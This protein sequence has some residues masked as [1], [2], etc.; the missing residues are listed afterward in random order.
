[1]LMIHGSSAP[2]KLKANA[3]DL[4]AWIFGVIPI[5]LA[6]VGLSLAGYLQF[7]SQTQFVPPHM[8]FSIL[9]TLAFSIAGSLIARRHPRNPIGWLLESV[10]GFSALIL[11]SGAYYGVSQTVSLPFERLSLWLQSWVWMPPTLIPLTLLLL[12]F[13]NGELISSRWRPILAFAVL[14]LVGISAAFAFNP[15]Q[16]FQESLGLPAPNPFAL[17]G[18]E[19]MFSAVLYLSGG[20]MVI[21]LVGSVASVI[22]R[23]RRS[24]GIRRTQLKWMA[25]A[26]VYICV[27]L[28]IASVLAALYP[29]VPMVEEATIIISNLVVAGIAVA[30][31]V[32]IVRHGLFDIDLLLNR[33]L[34]YLGLT[35]LVIGIYV[36]AVGLLSLLFRSAGDLAVSLAAT[37]VVAVALQPIKTRLQTGV[38]RMLYGARDDPYGVISS[39]G[40]RLGST[41]APEA[42]LPTL[43]ETIAQA[44]KLPYV[45]IRLATEEGSRIAAASGEFHGEM[46]RLPLQYQSER[47]GDLLVSPRAPGERFSPT[48]HHLLED[49]AEQASVAVHAN[50]LTNDLLHAHRRLLRAREEE[51]RRIRRDL[52]DGLGTLLASQRLKIGS[53]LEALDQGTPVARDLLQDLEQGVSQALEDIR[54]LVYDL[55]PPAL[56]ELGLVRALKQSA[57]RVPDTTIDFDVPREIPDLPAAVDVAAFRIIQEALNNCV[58]HAHASRV[59]VGITADEYLELS[60]RDNGIGIPARMQTGVGLNSMRARAEELG[61]TFELEGAA[62][63]GT[64]VRARLPLGESNY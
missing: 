27:G 62:G 63:G 40:H 56:D 54:R 48:E 51:R 50:R 28:L 46:K 37:G 24:S 25:Y 45:A 52:H 55:R 57:P 30:A 23:Y 18:A 44:L 8:L 49:I 17:A 59:T 60:I 64:E 10:G 4:M 35:G 39:L 38:N 47:L 16:G 1:M 3:V 7:S 21:A 41:I 33:T 43:V 6:L 5:I 34:V 19:A 22:I 26:G 20:L 58:R 11:L 29:G 2:Q 9:S 31:G 36:V 14:G 12:V 61:G 42:V 32:A 13:P 53:T 15:V